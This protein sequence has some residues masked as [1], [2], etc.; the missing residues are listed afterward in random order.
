M[1]WEEA[2]ESGNALIDKQHQ[3]LFRLASSLMS[4]LTEDRPLSEVSLCLE[5]L[6]AH[7][8]QHFHDEE[9]LLRAA[10]YRDP[11]GHAALHASL[12]AKARALQAEVQAGHL[13]FGKLVSFLAM[14]LVKGH[15]LSEDQGYFSHLVAVIGPDATP[16]AGFYWAIC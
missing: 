1:I 11:A 12:L 14:D 8:A 7:T 10:R 6:L 9:A 15:I 2:Y 3:R 13:D 5:T 4:V 16:K